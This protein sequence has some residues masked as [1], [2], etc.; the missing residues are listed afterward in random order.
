MKQDSLVPGVLTEM[1]AKAQA[2]Y[3]FYE[4]VKGVANEVGHGLEAA[5][6]CQ[7]DTSAI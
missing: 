4:R 1:L 6:P 5:H 2:P 7:L 3:I